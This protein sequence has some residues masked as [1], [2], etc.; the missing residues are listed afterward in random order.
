MIDGWWLMIL[1]ILMT[2]YW[3]IMDDWWWVTNRY[4]VQLQWNGH[5]SKEALPAR[6][7]EAV[8]AEEEHVVARTRRGDWVMSMGIPGS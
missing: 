2:D 1:M 4:I 3:L 5:V 7:A 6:L 8:E